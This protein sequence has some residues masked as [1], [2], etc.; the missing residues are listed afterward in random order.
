M[1]MNNHNLRL[2]KNLQYRKEDEAMK[3]Q[4]DEFYIDILDTYYKSLYNV[5]L[6]RLF[7][8]LNKKEDSLT[9]E[10]PYEQAL[11]FVKAELPDVMEIID[12]DNDSDIQLENDE[13]L[14]IVNSGFKNMNPSL[15]QLK[16]EDEGNTA[17]KINMKS[18]CGEGVIKQKTN[19][20]AMNTVED[21]LTGNN[22][23]EIKT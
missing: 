14:G 20:K 9:I 12:I 3:V 15:I 10:Q 16:L 2:F 6:I 1:E 5:K 17:T 11:E 13:F 23:D 21:Y 8:K 18:Y 22:M 4:N 7:T 19:K